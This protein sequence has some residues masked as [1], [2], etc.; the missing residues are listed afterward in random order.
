MYLI[1]DTET[2]GLPHNKTAPL[3]DLEN[4]PR[5]VQIAWQVH[6]RNGKL[7]SQH[8]YIVKPNGFDIP[9]KAEQ[10]H[11]ISTQRALAEGHEVNEVLTHFVKDLTHTKLLVGH[12]IEFD[13]NIIGAEFIRQGIDTQAFLSL[14]KL[15]TGIASIDFC[16]LPGGLGGKLKMPRLHELYEKLFG[17]SFE[18]AHD[19]SYDVAAT[20]EAFFE[21][22]RHKVVAP[23]DATPVEEIVYEAP[24]LEAGNSS[25]REKKKGSGYTT[26][27]LKEGLTDDP[28]CHLHLHSQFS[29]LQAVPNVNEIIARAKEQGMVAVALTDFGNMYGAFKFVSEALKHNIK[30]IV[31]CELFI[32]EER[33]K[34]KFTKDNPDKRYQQVLLAKN[35]TGYQN[36][37]KL[38]SLG[39]IEGLYGIYPRV[40]KELIAQ[41]KEGL[42]ATTGGLNSEIPYLILHVGEKQAEEV[43][44][45]WHQLFGNDFY[46]ELN[47][48]DT[49]EEDRVNETLLKFAGKYGV[50]YF[51]ANECFY[52]SKEES[53]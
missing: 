12:N 22:L 4:W 11:G 38:S 40:D 48:H 16:Q 37:A 1:F 15:D 6:G 23:A 8:N 39:F 2:T 24:Q 49:R 26:D 45:W 21:L 53:N 10:V 51:A 13:I 25:K 31:G 46:I 35:K 3:T 41:Y 27:E 14:Q 20:A 33:K 9:F 28:F 44:V 42:I 34:L 32:S 36:L 5:L 43:F 19:A 29:V 47:R 7:L 50:K 17:K 52:L 18:D 30:P